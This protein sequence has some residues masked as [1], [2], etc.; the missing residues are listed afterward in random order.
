MGN[1]VARSQVAW[2]RAE[3][4]QYRRDNSLTLEEMAR[5]MECSRRTVVNIESGTAGLAPK[6]VRAWLR[7][8]EGA[9]TAET[10]DGPAPTTPSVES[11]PAENSEGESK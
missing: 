6:T 9:P 10:A 2:L 4:R 3:V 7:L 11:V 8:R 5:R 1:A